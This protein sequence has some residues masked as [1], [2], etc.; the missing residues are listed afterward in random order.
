MKNNKD[1]SLNQ[2]LLDQFEKGNIEE[3]HYISR[4]KTVLTHL[5]ACGSEVYGFTKYVCADCHHTEI[6]YG[7]CGDA[8]CPKCGA[9]IRKRWIEEQTE[10]AVAATAWHIVFTNPDLYLNSL[11]LHDPR[12]FYNAMFRASSKAIKRL[13]RNKKYFGCVKPG[14]FSVLHTWGSTL[15]FHPHIHMVLY[16]AGLDKEGNLVVAKGEERYLFPVQKLAALYK[17]CLMAELN[18][19]Y[20]KSGSEWKQDLDKA[21]R[22]NWNVQI[23]KGL[24]HPARAIAYL[25]RYVNRVAIS[26]SRIRGYDGRFVTFEYKDYRDHGGFRKEDGREDRSGARKKLMKLKAEE[27][28]RRFT[29]HILPKNFRRTRFYGFLAHGQEESLARMKELTGTP[30]LTKEG[31]QKMISGSFGSDE[32]NGEEADEQKYIDEYE[33]PKCHKKMKFSGAAPRVRANAYEIRQYLR[34]RKET[35]RY[36]KKVSAKD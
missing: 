20:G 22:Q 19:K 6:H 28:V 7:T 16:G 21:A 1:C 29:L 32:R 15:S 18:K 30:A 23:N 8:H 9:A 5:A 24:D 31:V 17:H 34:V 3:T 2:I 13:S 4:V 14:F 27:F 10:K 25:G 35:G 33:C 26:N 11:A 12:F 36:E